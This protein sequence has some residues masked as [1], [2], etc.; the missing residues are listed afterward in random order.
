MPAA[1]TSRQPG[2]GTLLFS[3]GFSSLLFVF[4]EPARF[5]PV[6]LA[7]FFLGIFC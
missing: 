6:I 1:G 4:P 3:S 7:G 5:Y 2:Q